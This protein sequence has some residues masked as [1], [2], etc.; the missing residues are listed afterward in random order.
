MQLVVLGL[1]YKTVPVAV[2]EQFSISADSARS[3]L[4][5]LD[6]QEGIREAV[7]LST[8][9]QRGCERGIFFLL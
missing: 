1:N 4:Q 7:V 2:R 5:H 6:E 3:G 8:F 9:R